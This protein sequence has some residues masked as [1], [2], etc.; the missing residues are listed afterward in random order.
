MKKVIE[1]LPV[2]LFLG[3]FE[4]TKENPQTPRIVFTLRTLKILDK[5]QKDQGNSQQ[6]NTKETKTPRKRRTGL[7]LTSFCGTLVFF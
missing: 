1:L 4:N 6:E 2:L 3:L 5:K 7:L